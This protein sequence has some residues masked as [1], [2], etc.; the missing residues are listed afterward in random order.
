MA[1]L[2]MPESFLCAMEEGESLSGVGILGSLCAFGTFV[3]EQ[4]GDTH[5]PYDCPT[6]TPGRLI[7]SPSE[8]EGQDGGIKLLMAPQGSE[9]QN[10]IQEGTAGSKAF[11]LGYSCLEKLTFLRI[12]DS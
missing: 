12:S 7:L 3:N 2:N 6:D 5:V 9:C 8:M 10:T 11:L 4:R 1:E